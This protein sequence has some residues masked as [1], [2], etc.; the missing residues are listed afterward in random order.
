MRRV[1][2]VTCNCCH[3]IAAYSFLH[4][5]IFILFYFYFY[6]YILFINTSSSFYLH[7]A[8]LQPAIRNLRPP[9][10]AMLGAATKTEIFPPCRTS[11]S[12]AQCGQRGN[13]E[14]NASLRGRSVGEL[15]MLCAD[16]A[17]AVGVKK[18]FLV[19]YYTSS[20]TFNLL[21]S[22]PRVPC[23][24]TCANTSPVA[25]MPALVQEPTFCRAPGTTRPGTATKEKAKRR[26]KDKNPSDGHTPSSGSRDPF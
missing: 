8:Q 5:S 24:A 1:E 3:C 23:A 11:A 6:F 13:L 12:S 22:R 18:T 16:V 17:M 9:R 14:N 7:L 25:R 10:S 26:A 19:L 2:Q 4:Y 21:A 15:E 20:P